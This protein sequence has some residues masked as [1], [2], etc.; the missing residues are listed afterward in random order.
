MLACYYLKSA[1]RSSRRFLAR[2]RARIETSILLCLPQAVRFQNLLKLGTTT[3]IF[4]SSFNLLTT[5][6]TTWM[7]PN[8]RVRLPSLAET[9]EYI[10]GRR[11]WDYT[12][13]SNSSAT[14]SPSA[15]LKL[16]A[17]LLAT[18]PSSQPS[19]SMTTVRHQ[20]V[21]L[22][23]VG[24]PRVIPPSQ[25]TTGPIE[26]I[27]RSM[28]VPKVRIPQHCDICGRTITRDLTRHMRTHD[29]VS[30]FKCVYP[31]AHCPHKTGRFNR[32]YDFK[33]H[34]IHSHFQ[35]NDPQVKKVKS[36]QHKLEHQGR[37]SCGVA[38][39]A[40]DWLR[41]IVDMDETGMYT[42]PDLRAKWISTQPSSQRESTV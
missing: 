27:D 24:V 19:S 6:T 12:T 18:A 25:N 34:L 26:V 3:R 11:S 40:S 2:G 28:V 16:A 30:R 22:P 15:T 10:R 5:A 36:L 9:E 21:F 38:M 7:P 41:H 8:E 13:A 32:Q 14:A 33:K 42:C 37:C 39:L 23:A 20:Q 4:S 17:P 35:L 29:S 1:C 31:A